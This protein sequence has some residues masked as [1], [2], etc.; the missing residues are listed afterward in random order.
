M[1]PERERITRLR[2]G[3]PPEPSGL[4]PARGRA[5][6][7]RGVDDLFADA[8]LEYGPAFQGIGAA[9]RQEEEP[10]VEASL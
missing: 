3:R 10:Y 8:G 7:D 5:A 4:A 9:W 6:R 1:D 2:A